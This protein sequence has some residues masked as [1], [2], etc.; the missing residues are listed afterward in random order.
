MSQNNAR[1]FLK[2]RKK[3]KKIYTSPFTRTQ[4]IQN[5]LVLEHR[6]IEPKQPSSGKRKVLKVQLVKSKKTKLVYVP[7]CGGREFI[8]LHDVVTVQSIGGRKGGP[9]GDLSG[10]NMRVI[11][12]NGTCLKQKFLGRK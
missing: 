1:K 9:M 2:K 12:V 8:K 4:H 11:K 5:A 6:T 7:Y 3:F 10:L